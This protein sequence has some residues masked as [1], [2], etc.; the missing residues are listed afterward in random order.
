MC[1]G[2]GRN[3]PCDGRFLGQKGLQGFADPESDRSFVASLM[4]LPLKKKYDI[5]LNVTTF[6]TLKYTCCS[7]VIFVFRNFFLFSSLRRNIPFVNISAIIH[8]SLNYCCLGYILT[9]RTKITNW[10][11]Y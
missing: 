7:L 11:K 3:R 10:L 1:V 9:F 6:E 2:W 5:L 8:S 4:H